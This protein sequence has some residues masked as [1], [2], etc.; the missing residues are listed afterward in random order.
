MQ[1]N[2]TNCFL[3]V[4]SKTPFEG[5]AYNNMLHGSSRAE[6]IENA[7]AALIGNHAKLLLDT[8]RAKSF[9]DFDYEGETMKL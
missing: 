3:H 6:A 4:T 9:D 8:V 5:R 2:A 1:R 7:F